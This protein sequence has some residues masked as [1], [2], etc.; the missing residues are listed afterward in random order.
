[1]QRNLGFLASREEQG[2]KV[3]VSKRHLD[4]ALGQFAE[5]QDQTTEQQLRVA[6][7]QHLETEPTQ[8][9]ID[10][11]EDDVLVVKYAEG[12]LEFQTRPSVFTHGCA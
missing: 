4:S 7:A 3:L 12:V 10:L 2:G 6:L 8:I 5:S 9:L 11:T 1:M